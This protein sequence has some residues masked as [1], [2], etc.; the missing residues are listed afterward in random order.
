VTWQLPEPLCLYVVPARA[1]P[2]L[3]AVVNAEG[4]GGAVRG[5][6]GVGDPRGGSRP[7]VVGDDIPVELPEAEIELRVLEHDEEAWRDSPEDDLAR[8][9]SGAEYDLVVELME[10]HDRVEAVEQTTG[11]A[12]RLAE[13]TRGTVLDPLCARTLPPPNP[14]TRPGDVEAHVVIHAVT[15]DDAED[16]TAWLHTHGLIKFGR[17]ELELKHVP[18]EL[19][20]VGA[21]FL[22]NLGQYLI[23]GAAVLPGETVG[24]RGAPLI[25]RQSNDVVEHEPEIPMVELVDVGDDGEPVERGVERG[26]RAWADE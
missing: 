23:D 14:N 2:D 22:N 7:L 13:L 8:A 21:R 18:P 24:A 3:S 26:L 25:A 9:V 5:R 1:L 16:E 12:R 15:G 20:E 4:T 17:P 19:V 11:V 6:P 10:V